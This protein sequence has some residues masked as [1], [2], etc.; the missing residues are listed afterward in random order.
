[1]SG[2]RI[3]QKMK[4]WFKRSSNEQTS[5][6]ETERVQQPP[7]GNVGNRS[8][9]A[10]YGGQMAPKM[11]GNTEWA[12]Q[13]TMAQMFKRLEAG[14]EKGQNANWFRAVDQNLDSVLANLQQSLSEDS[15]KN[16]DILTQVMLDYTNLITA[17]Q[18]YLK[19]R[20][21]EEIVSQILAMAQRDLQSIRGY[22]DIMAKEPKAVKAKT[23]KEMIE[24]GRQRTIQLEKGQR[25]AELEHVGGAAS[26]L[27][28]IRQKHLA[29][30]KKEGEEGEKIEGF[31][32][33]EDIFINQ[34]SKDAAM[35]I[36]KQLAKKLS[37]SKEHYDVIEDAI[38]K[39]DD[40]IEHASQVIR[41]ACQSLPQYWNNQEFH[42]FTD[43]LFKACDGYRET[44]GH[45]L[46]GE[47]D[48]KLKEGESVNMSKR[49]V[50]ASRIANLFGVGEL[51]AQS[52]TANLK[53]ADNTERSGNFMQ[54]AQG[55]L[56]SQTYMNF[57]R[58]EYQEYRKKN[59]YSKN[60]G[61]S[62]VDNY[63]TP[64]FLK[65]LTSLQVLDNLMSQSDR[66]KNNYMVEQN[67]KRELG[68]VQGI[69]NDFSFSHTV[70]FGN[71]SGG[72]AHGRS[73]FHG[74]ITEENGDE[75]ELSLPYMDKALAERIL[76][77]KETDVRMILADV[78]EQ[79]AV[80]AFCKR[81]KIMQ[82]AIQREK[83]KEREQNTPTR[84]LSD[85]K[86]WT[87]KAMPA[88]QKDSE[89]SAPR[90]YV[91]VYMKDA[92]SEFT[93]LGALEKEEKENMVK[94]VWQR[95]REN[96]TFD[97]P[98]KEYQFLKECGIE[99][100]ILDYLKKTGQ[101]NGDMGIIKKFDDDS[102]S[103]KIYRREI[104]RIQEEAK[105]QEGPKA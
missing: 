59:F 64:K 38:K 52:E 21:G 95:E 27:A 103:K 30:G 104:R 80:D 76:T 92:G 15:E 24:K 44:K 99:T 63:L 19:Y 98:D 50:A 82:G 74:K 33:E 51:I 29:G 48:V 43:A 11:V 68:G 28:V 85:D 8:R 72:F 47:V 77:V 25:E 83:K 41:S 32:K 60:P 86:E 12:A 45:M 96:G 53:D 10:F 62:R 6:G 42:E 5:A 39:A 101:L 3:R 100:K 102:F 26:S 66:H 73:V 81:L 40:E 57:H 65:S 55:I 61:I 88:F 23:V 35:R 90:T 20:D 89:N 94:E 31:F 34:N 93:V 70:Y 84:F 56:G 79:G 54:A 49:N 17:C 87:E 1:M 58:K 69:D 75:A 78:L 18:A 46:S 67:A 2:G 13:Y 71:A 22:G 36:F 97:T 14:E 105:T 91:G 7:R 16:Q 37:L 4:S 9:R